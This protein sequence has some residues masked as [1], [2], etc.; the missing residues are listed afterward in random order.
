MVFISDINYGPT[1]S[2]RPR[3]FVE[4]DHLH[5]PSLIQAF[6][7]LQRGWSE[8]LS[9]PFKFQSVLHGTFQNGLCIT[10]PRQRLPKAGPCDIRGVG[11]RTRIVQTPSQTEFTPYTF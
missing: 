9:F 8:I 1:L 3:Q 6:Y 10:Q 11:V 5:I 2:A 4:P 7:W